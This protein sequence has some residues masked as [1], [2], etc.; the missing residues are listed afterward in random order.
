VRKALIFENYPGAFSLEQE[1]PVAKLA[2]STLSPFWDLP[3]FSF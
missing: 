1:S 2:F 3:A